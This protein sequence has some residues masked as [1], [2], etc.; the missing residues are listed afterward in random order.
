MSAD[1]NDT[2][3]AE[4]LRQEWKILLTIRP[5]LTMCIAFDKELKAVTRCK[6]F[7][8]RNERF[9][10]MFLDHRDMLV[11][12]LCSWAAS[13]YSGE[14]RLNELKERHCSELARQR[15][16]GDGDGEWIEQHYDRGH[17]EAFARLFPES[18][19]RLPQSSTWTPSGRAYK[20]TTSRLIATE[21]TTVPTVTRTAI[22]LLARRCWNSSACRN[23]LSSA[24]S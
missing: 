15:R 3:L 24:G 21:T 5:R 19:G 9:W 7:A 2:S 10:N 20:S 18:A 8:I 14:T 1:N 12:D 11:I 6:S 17:S 22:T 16:W 23:S 4:F 13:I